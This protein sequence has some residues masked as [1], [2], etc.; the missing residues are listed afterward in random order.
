MGRRG[1]AWGARHASLLRSSLACAPGKSVFLFLFAMIFS[2]DLLFLLLHLLHLSHRA[3]FAR[4]ASLR[5]IVWI[6]PPKH[7]PMC[8]FGVAT[9]LPASVGISLILKWVHTMALTWGVCMLLFHSLT[10][11]LVPLLD[12]NLTTTYMDGAAW[13]MGGTKTCITDSLTLWVLLVCFAGAYFPFL[14]LL[15]FTL[16]SL[17]FLL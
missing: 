3:K 17:T 10:D 6:W 11:N 13:Y 15:Y 7:P 2:F 14:S 16:L 4:G 9:V 12:N 1:V 5:H 8:C